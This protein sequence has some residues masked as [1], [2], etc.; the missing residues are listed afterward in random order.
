[1]KMF[2]P[3]K[4]KGPETSVSGK[5]PPIITGV[6][7][8]GDPSTFANSPTIPSEFYDAMPKP[9]REGCQA[10]TT[11]REKDAF[12]LAALGVLSG[13]MPTVQGVYAG[14]Q[15]G[16]N[17]FVFIIAPAGSG[18]GSLVW[19]RQL[20]VGY[21]KQKR[22]QSDEAQQA[23][24][25]RRAEARQ[26]GHSFDERA[27]PYKTLFLPGNSS[28]AAFLK[29]L[30]EN[31][32]QGVVCETEADTLSGALK[33]DWGDYSDV[34]R[35][36]FHHE[37]ISYQRKS[38]ER[39]EI[40]HPAI[41]V[42]LSGTPGQVSKLIPDSENGL[43]SR[44]LFYCYQ[45]EATWR[46][47]S[48]DSSRLTLNQHFVELVN[49]TTKMALDLEEVSEINV[50]WTSCHWQIFNQTM[51][52]QLAKALMRLP[53]SI[54]STV[55]RIGLMVYRISMILTVLRHC[56]E[57]K[58]AETMHCSD[59]DFGMAM[60]LSS[61]LLEHALVMSATMPQTGWS[62]GS[63]K[64]RQF[65]DQLPNTFNRTQAE[66]L[67]TAIGIKTRSVTNY[68]SQLTQIGQLAKVEHGMYK[69]P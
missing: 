1:M 61:V 6:L 30:V 20:G 25:Q 36:A 62:G 60:D 15:V 68:L 42:V 8:K 23:Y 41:S 4:A 55:Y 45:T 34:L 31:D 56:E 26:S 69:K 19:A 46:D 52:R 67:A 17:L 38:G 29:S 54:S 9:L 50:E 37:P 48:P 35:K 3:I 47:V 65:Y 58:I 32:E 59:T 12:L 21:H 66:E 10:F 27:P 40:D 57:Q 5:Q 11:Q 64:Q 49:Y 18:K 39:Y 51:E 16:T 7:N 24:E 43:F 33:Q 14:S 13:C 28:S 22:A 63:S 53:E 2:Q 44:F